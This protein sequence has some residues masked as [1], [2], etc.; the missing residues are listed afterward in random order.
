MREDMITPIMWVALGLLVGVVLG[1][2]AVPLF[3]PRETYIVEILSEPN[4]RECALSIGIERSVL[5]RLIGMG[6]GVRGS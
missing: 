6:E 5:G 2:W 4:T 3:E 1:R